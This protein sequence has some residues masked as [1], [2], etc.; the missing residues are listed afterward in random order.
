L[1]QTKPPAPV[2]IEQ[3]SFFA[4]FLSE[5]AVFRQQVIDGLLLS[6]IDPTGKDQ[7]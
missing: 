4:E 3:D 7:E 5:Y 1:R 6:T 2:V